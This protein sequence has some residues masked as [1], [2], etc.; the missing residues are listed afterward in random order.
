[1]FRSSVNNS[2]KSSTHP[3]FPIGT[4][5]QTVYQTVAEVKFLLVE[6]NCYRKKYRTRKPPFWNPWWHTGSR[7]GSVPATPWAEKVHRE[8]RWSREADSTVAACKPQHHA[9][10]VGQSTVSSALCSDTAASPQHELW[11]GEDWA[12]GPSKPPELPA[13]LQTFKAWGHVKISWAGR[14]PDAEFGRF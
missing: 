12:R 6:A 1:V 7:H 3:S 11:E 14:R 13:S 2:E 5:L 10:K 9:R 4:I 8:L